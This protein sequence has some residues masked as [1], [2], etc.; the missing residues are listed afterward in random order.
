[1]KNINDNNDTMKY[2]YT[3]PQ[4]TIIEV[5]A[6]RGFADSGNAPGDIYWDD[7]D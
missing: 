2:S 5:N 7:I 6:E 3:E 4:L 1:M